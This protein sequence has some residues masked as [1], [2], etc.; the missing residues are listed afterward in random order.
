MLCLLYIY[1]FFPLFFS[2]VDPE[3]AADAAV[4]DYIN[5]NPLFPFSGASRQAPSL[6]IPISP[7]PSSLLLALDFATVIDCSY[8]YA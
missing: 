7:I 5:D 1:Y 3:T 8:F 6:I 4:I 2:P